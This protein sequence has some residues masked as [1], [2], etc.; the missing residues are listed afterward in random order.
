MQRLNQ[1]RAA[2][3]C[4]VEEVAAVLG[5][6]RPGESADRLITPTHDRDYLD[7]AARLADDGNAV[8]LIELIRK[9]R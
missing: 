4:N 2:F 9:H 5:R 7:T 3:K 6:I 8:E 1:E